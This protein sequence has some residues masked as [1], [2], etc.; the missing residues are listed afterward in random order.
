MHVRFRLV[1][2]ASNTRELSIPLPIVVGRGP[3][4]GLRLPQQSVSRRHCELFETDGVVF[5]RDLGSTNGTVIGGQRVSGS[6]AIAVESGNEVQV[7]DVR[8]RVAFDQPV[9]RRQPAAEAAAAVVSAAADVDDVRVPDLTAAVEEAAAVEIP[10]LDIPDLPA[11]GGPPP[12][13]Q[14]DAAPPP[15]PGADEP[16]AEAAPHFDVGPAPT[17]DAFAFPGAEAEPAEPPAGFD[18]LAPDSTPVKTD[19]GNLDDFLKGLQ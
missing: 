1:S 10:D 7:G 6:A 5:V 3:E 11:T 13:A 15:F 8:F 12:L 19:D 2:P 17:T 18:F 9:G 14:P 4:A 16:A